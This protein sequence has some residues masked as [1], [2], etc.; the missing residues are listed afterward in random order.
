MKRFLI[1]FFSFFIICLTLLLPVRQGASY[2]LSGYKWSD[3]NLP[4]AYRVNTAN[5]PLYLASSFVD[6]VQSGFQTWSDVPC[7]DMAFVYDGST[8]ATVS[9]DDTRTVCWSSGED[10]GEA[11]AIAWQWVS[12]GDRFLDADMELNGGV[13]WS[14][15]G[16]SG[17][18]DLQSVITH[19][20][21]HFVG[22][23]DL[24]SVADR[25]ST[26]Y[27]YL[28]PGDVGPRTLASDDEA[29]IC[30]LYPANEL[31]IL[32]VSM[33]KAFI[34]KPYR[35]E[36][37]AG[38]GVAPYTWRVS[39]GALPTGLILHGDT[40]V[41]EG[42]PGTEGTFSST[43]EVADGEGTTQIRGFTIEATLTLQPDIFGVEIGNS[44]TSQEGSITSADNIVSVDT[45]TFPV[46]TYIIESREKGV[47]IDKSWYERT[48]TEVKLWG[49]YDEDIG[50][51]KFSNGLIY[52]WYP[53]AEG[54]K[55][56]SHATIMIY[57]VLF[58][59][60]LT[61]TVTSKETLILPFGTVEAFKIKV[62]LYMCGPGLD[63]TDIYYDWVVPYLAIVKS[64]DSDGSV[65]ELVSFSIGGGTITEGTDSDEDGLKDYEELVVYGTDRV[66]ADT[67]GD[68][69]Y[70]GAEVS[71]GRDPN[72]QDSQGDINGDF[73]INLQDAIKALQIMAGMQSSSTITYNQE[74]DVNKDGRLGMEEVI[75]IL[76]KI[77][78]LR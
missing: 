66:N 58:D 35:Q 27:G 39:S 76:Q 73:Y 48:D 29:G 70:D 5:C 75:Y 6:V 64:Q 3:I 72:V 23:G 9:N 17:K 15:S 59:V 24:Y 16:E 77:S 18:Y 46:T 31:V 11:L 28:F 36:L 4:L 67:D 68:G 38:G 25:G 54:E 62:K 32:T 40:G 1:R 10:M 52:F 30:F 51:I 42:T 53:M 63:E 21:G 65:E 60:E 57:G 47:L 7:S 61:V 56:Y 33:P 34:D 14:V 55:R 20:A 22:L 74:A 44:W 78:G 69:C 19:E 37:E 71:L 8:T 50:E 45:T 12:P 13:A 43:I 26:M 41:I 2:E 49:G